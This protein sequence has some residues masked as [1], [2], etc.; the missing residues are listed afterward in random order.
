MTRAELLCS[1]E[2]LHL[3]IIITTTRGQICRGPILV[4]ETIRKEKGLLVVRT[5][6]KVISDDYIP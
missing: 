2:I 4:L 1:L 5:R 6:P 3:E